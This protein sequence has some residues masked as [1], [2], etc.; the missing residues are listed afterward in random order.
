MSDT[1]KRTPWTAFEKSMVGVI[2]ASLIAVGIFWTVAATTPLTAEE[3]VIAAKNAEIRKHNAEID[4]HNAPIL[5]HNAEVAALNAAANAAAAK[6][7]AE[8]AR[9]NYNAGGTLGWMVDEQDKRVLSR[10]I[11]NA[12]GTIE[13]CYVKAYHR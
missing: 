11:N 2:G 8:Q 4:A 6:E 3:T 10:C 9:Q 7:A 13:D 12:E 5:A 1:K